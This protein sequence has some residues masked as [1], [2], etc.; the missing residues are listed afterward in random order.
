MFENVEGRF[1]PPDEHRPLLCFGAPWFQYA[2][3]RK[4]LNLA[5]E[6]IDRSLALY[7]PQRPAIYDDNTGR[8]WTYGEL[9]AAVNRLGNAFRRLGVQPGERVIMRFGERPEAAISQLAVWKVGAI[10]VPTSVLDS[11]RELSSIAADTE[12]RWLVC[13][14]ANFAEVEKALAQPNCLSG[15]IVAG[16][17]S[18]AAG[19]YLSFAKLIADESESLEPYPTRA[20]DAAIIG[21]TGGTTGHPKGCIHTHAGYLAISDLNAIYRGVSHTDVLLCHAP[22]GHAFGNGEKIAIP[23]RW[24]AATVYRER[25]S[26]EDMWRLL[27]RYRVTA[28]AGIATM[29]RMMARVEGELPPDLKLRSALSTGEMLDEAGA[30]RWS[31]MAGVELRN[32]VGMVPMAHIFLESNDLNARRVA[33]GLSVGMPMAGYEAKVVAL[34]SLTELEPG[35]TGRLAVRGPT[36]ITYWTNKHPGIRERATRDVIGGWSLL[37]D[38]Y[39]RDEDG[40]LYI[41]G[42]LDDMIVTA[43]RQISAVE[44]ETV[45]LSHPGVREAA[46]FAAPDPIRGQ[47]VAACVVPAPQV[48]PSDDFKA[49]LQ[50]YCKENLA[51]YKYPRQIQF[52]ASLPRD[53]VGKLRRRLLKEA[54]GTSSAAAA[55]PRPTVKVT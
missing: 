28:M 26:A 44:V 38:A 41:T 24:G 46:V 17:A 40:W 34:D 4:S 37:D 3:N 42:R 47:V 11:A 55:E 25:P 35:E 7:G 13:E 5:H 23:L 50:R 6:I 54:F 29:Y 32:V 31:K 49:E 15:V 21:Y 52:A 20:L 53:E 10:A 14:A 48:T 36:G 8:T 19:S 30:A 51:A 33:P 18:A 45:L 43:G 12:A 22:L 9:N 1:L 2:H 39:R 27:G 16:G